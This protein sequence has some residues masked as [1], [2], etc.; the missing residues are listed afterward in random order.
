MIRNRH[1]E[2]NE[3][4]ASPCA[5]MYGTRTATT[6]RNCSRPPR[7]R[8][9]TTTRSPANLSYRAISHAY[10][11]WVYYLRVI[12][13]DVIGRRYAPEFIDGTRARLE[14]TTNIVALP[15]E[16]GGVRKR[17]VSVVPVHPSQLCSFF[18]FRFVDPR[19]SHDRLL[20]FR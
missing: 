4:R 5:F 6:R 7:L 3:E 2:N 17:V 8:N 19:K 15:R 16:G 9:L 18:S 10:R 20:I 13:R 1:A 11:E 12:P 14:E